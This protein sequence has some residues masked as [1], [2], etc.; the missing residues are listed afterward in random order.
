MKVSQAQQ[1]EAFDDLVATLNAAI[2]V[3]GVMRFFD[4]TAPLTCEDADDGFL[5]VENALN[6]TPIQ[7]PSGLVADFGAI[8]DGIAVANGT[9][10]YARVYDSGGTTCVLQ[11]TCG[12]SGEEI[13]FDDNVFVI[14]GVCHIAALA[15]ASSFLG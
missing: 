14:D 13:V 2:G 10:Q 5:V 9:V 7:A 4:G 6:A 11:F 3:T 8:E 1:I 12:V 15:V